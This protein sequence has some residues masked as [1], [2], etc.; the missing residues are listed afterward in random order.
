MSKDRYTSKYKRKPSWGSA[1]SVLVSIL[2]LLAA[3]QMPLVAINTTPNLENG[4][5]KLFIC[6]NVDGLTTERLYNFAPIYSKDGLLRLLREGLVYPQ[7][8]IDFSPVDAASALASIYTGTY[9]C[10]HGIT[11]A[12]KYDYRTHQRTPAAEDNAYM[13][14]YTSDRMSP[15]ALLVPTL[16]DALKTASQGRSSVYS[17][18]P[19]AEEALFSAGKLADGAF[20]IDSRRATWATTTYYTKQIPWWIDQ[21]N[22]GAQSLSQRMPSMV[23][24]PLTKG[25]SNKLAPY[26]SSSLSFSHR[27]G[28]SVDKFKESALVNDEVADLALQ[29]IQSAGYEYAT[30]P[31]L[32]NVTFYT[33]TYSAAIDGSAGGE[34]LDSYARLDQAIAKLLAAL[35]KKVGSGGYT[36]MLTGTGRSKEGLLP[37]S[38]NGYKAKTFSH[39]RAKA[40]LNMYL[41]AIYGQA[42]WV[43]DSHEGQIWLDNKLIESKGIDLNEITKSAANFLAEMEGVMWA[44]PTQALAPLDVREGAEVLAKNHH[45]SSGASIILRFTPGWYSEDALSDKRRSQARY[46]AIPSPLIFFGNGIEHRVMHEVNPKFEEIVSTIS[47][48]LRIRP[49]NGATGKILGEFLQLPY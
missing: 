25:V 32:L 2:S 45:A 37:Y 39:Q 16:G 17:I 14:N 44:V 33:D 27:V 13:G 49:P 15:R 8:Q 18:A 28:T 10:T 7:M 38:T 43:L 19:T 41:M 23:W 20:W 3:A 29:F 36:L 21:S 31:H 46:D 11:A 35:D 47:F 9:P 12:T 42:D 48:I 4:L 30:T 26:A 5:P 40:L 24:T 6:I 22:R 1:S 34:M